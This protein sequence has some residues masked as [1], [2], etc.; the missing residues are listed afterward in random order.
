M[1]SRHPS[2]ATAPEGAPPL[3]GEPLALE[4]ANTVFPMRGVLQDGF[5]TPEHVSWWL[6]SC[7]H[8]FATPLREPDLAAIDQT[9]AHCFVL[10]RDS[11]R[12][13]IDAHIQGHDPERWD[14]AQVNR[15]SALGRPWPSLLW[16]AGRRPAALHCSTAP[17][18]VAAQTEIAQAL[19]E[20][21]AGITEV[22]PT[23][24]PAP[25][26]VFFFDAGRARRQWCSQGCGN[27]AR[28]ARH[29]ARHQSGSTSSHS[30]I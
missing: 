28:A 5:R 1:S 8:L 7:R 12:R 2:P 17:P 16:E 14:I 3:N 19:I 21:L 10:L 13:L 6:R 9:D 11:A 4:F 18:A 29:Y 26:C 24:C 27:R 23:A 15:V 22:R 30:P 20:L 25:G